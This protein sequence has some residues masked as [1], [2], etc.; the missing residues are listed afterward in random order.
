MLC[1]TCQQL[2]EHRVRATRHLYKAT[3]KLIELTR[4]RDPELFLAAFHER[5]NCRHECQQLDLALRT[6]RNSDGC[7]SARG[8][9]RP[10]ADKIHQTPQHFS[11]PDGFS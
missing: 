5:E 1:Y 9:R 3:A 7:L 2:L 11:N 6:H 4:K 10:I 8:G